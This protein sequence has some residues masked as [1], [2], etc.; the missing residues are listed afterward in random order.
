M[1]PG[2]GL[3]LLCIALWG[4]LAVGCAPSA[5]LFNSTSD[6]S[7]F[8]QTAPP[9]CEL[10]WTWEREAQI[11]HIAVRSAATSGWLGVGFPT[12]AGVMAPAVA[13]IGTSAGVSSYSLSARSLD[14]VVPN[15]AEGVNMNLTGT[16]YTNSGGSAI[17]RFT[18][19][20]IGFQTGAVPINI[21][22]DLN[23]LDL[24]THDAS[25]SAA[26]T[27][28]FV[29]AELSED[30][31]MKDYRKA[32]AALMIV[33]WCYLV[34]FGIIIKR[35][36]KPV[37]TLGNSIKRGSIGLAFK[38]H[39]G[40]MMLACILV[41]AGFAI[42]YQHFRTT[43]SEIDHGNHN[44]WGY[45]VFVLLVCTPIIGTLGPGL[46]PTKSHRG[47]AL[48]AFVH[49]GLGALATIIAIV[50]CFSGFKKLRMTDP[51]TTDSLREVALI[52]IAGNVAMILS[53]EFIKSFFY[54]RRI[55]RPRN[56]AS[57]SSKI[58]W[59]EI[60]THDTTASD[61]WVVLHGRVFA[62][63][64]WLDKHPGGQEVVLEHAGKDA[65]EPF[66]KEAHSLD[67]RKIIERFYV[68]DVEDER[69]ISSI[70]LSEEIARSL[71]RLDLESANNLIKE[72]ID[73][74]PYSLLTSFSS[75]VD[76]LNSY[77]PYL[78][79][80]L[81]DG[82]QDDLQH[83]QS[84]DNPN[85]GGGTQSEL[86]L[87]YENNPPNFIA[88]VFTDIQSSTQL[89][90]ASPTGMKSGLQLHNTVMRSVIEETGGY[91]VKTIGDAFMVAFREVTNAVNFALKV[92]VALTLQKWPP[93]LLELPLCTEHKTDSGQNVWGG[94]RVR[95]GV[96]CGEVDPQKNP[97]TGRIDFFGN[98]INKAARVE[99]VAA[100]GSVAVTE[101]VLSSIR[102]ADFDGLDQIQLGKVPLKGVTKLSSITCILPSELR[103]RRAEIVVALNT[104]KD[105][106]NPKLLDRHTSLSSPATHTKVVKT[107][108]HANHSTV[109]AISMNFKYLKHTSDAADSVNVFYATILDQAIRTQGVSQGAVGGIFC[110]TWNL[111]KRCLQHITHSIRF[112]VGLRS[113]GIHKLMISVKLDDLHQAPASPVSSA[114][115]S[116]ISP[117]SSPVMI[118]NG[119]SKNDKPPLPRS[120]GMPPLIPTPKTVVLPKGYQTVVQSHEV[121]GGLLHV[122]LSTGLTL[123]G[124]V[125]NEV[126][127]AIIAIG[128]A[129]DLAVAI[130]RHAS[131][132]GSYCLATT[133]PGSYGV[134]EDPTISDCARPIDVWHSDNTTTTIHEINI[135]TLSAT[136]SSWG[137]SPEG[138][139]DPSWD[140]DFKELVMECLQK[141]SKPA[142]QKIRSTIDAV[143]KTRQCESCRP[144]ISNFYC[145][146]CDRVTC[147]RCSALNCGNHDVVIEQKGNVDALLFI[148]SNCE[149]AVAKN[150]KATYH[151]SLDL[152]ERPTDT[153]LGH[154]SSAF[155]RLQSIRSKGSNR[156]KLDVDLA[157]SS[158]SFRDK[159]PATSPIGI[160]IGINQPLRPAAPAASRYIA[161]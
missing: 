28:N 106:E 4:Q 44:I 46:V 74:V 17:I 1:K 144:G 99:G 111:S 109:A 115:D 140:K 105:G 77:R 47:R 64:T 126:Q 147:T 29:T 98:T 160:N 95:I 61:P 15:D 57:N 62:I 135:A 79:S 68:G 130:S 2:I 26:R 142:L 78:P 3:L 37:F 155:A 153:W 125:G 69:M 70:S 14:G 150:K 66:N 10:H 123:S 20:S 22:R 119:L 41:V 138:P 65:T 93:S 49:P 42:A 39:V 114:A 128:G 48:F 9:G 100:G 133:M 80:G 38:L 18:R 120:E 34:P 89:W 54:I 75:L 83:F 51:D 154:G 151:M 53:F 110:I 19:S 161:K 72:S 40:L 76:N 145:T 96:H 7:C 32:H 11:I 158:P 85:Q 148:K 131:D 81:L 71:V 50:Q 143:L 6:Y 21:A 33:A 91:E 73:E 87:S 88:I 141:R 86:S 8:V 35:Y 137:F 102:L 84:T 56:L 12:T 13:I 107:N 16:S 112:A 27:L 156:G 122:G 139:P 94:P 59:Q 129:V 43:G 52:G 108:F 117:P 23:F 67:A 60:A 58:S 104:K 5:L 146:D 101:E 127:K 90:E 36:G 25:Q 121:W 103:D 157:S 136:M 113:A 132:I 149:L 55:N 118:P 63:K 30:T 152:R 24:N 134:P 116:A 31:T 92:Q 159:S 82:S 45:V 97:M 124:R